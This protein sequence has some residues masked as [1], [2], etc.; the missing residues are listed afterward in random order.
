M[1]S[2]SSGKHGKKKLSPAE[3]NL[4]AG[5]RLLHNHSLFGGLKGEL[6]PRNQQA[7]GKTTPALVNSDGYIY[8][9]Q[10]ILLAPKQWL[11]LIAHCLLHLAFGHFDAE[12]MPAYEIEDSDGKPIRKVSFQPF[13]WNEEIGRAHV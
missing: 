13:L 6:L 9:N 2:K 11:F 5:M 8:L 12:N 4:Q 3:K 7:L 1:A 10:D